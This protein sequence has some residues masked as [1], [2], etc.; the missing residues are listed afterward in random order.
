VDVIQD[1]VECKWQSVLDCRKS[2]HDGNYG[3]KFRACSV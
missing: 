2:N 1:N 3:T